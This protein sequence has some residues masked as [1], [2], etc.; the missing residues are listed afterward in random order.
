MTCTVLAAQPQSGKRKSDGSPFHFCRVWVMLD[1]GS[2]TEL[3]ARD[4]YAPGDVIEVA[5]V[6]RYGKVALVPASEIMR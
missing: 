5:V 1:D 2:A 4:D 6:T 3:T